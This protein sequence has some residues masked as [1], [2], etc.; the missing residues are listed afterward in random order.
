[1]RLIS[2]TVQWCRGMDGRG[3]PKRIAA[4]A[5]RL[6][7]PDVICLQELARN[8]PD[9]EGTASED[10]VLEL[11]LEGYQGFFAPAVD[12][13]EK[14]GRRRFGLIL[15]RLPTSFLSLNRHRGQ[16]ETGL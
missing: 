10:Q 8:F 14:K 11:I 15:T 6:A 4:E 13:P 7:D 1:M 2:W 9:M 12:I 16:S 5:R 3:D